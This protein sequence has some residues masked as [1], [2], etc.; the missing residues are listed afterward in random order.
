MITSVT[1]RFIL[2]VLSTSSTVSALM[3]LFPVTVSLHSANL[4]LRHC[5]WLSGISDSAHGHLYLSVKPLSP[6]SETLKR[7]H[8]FSG[9]LKRAHLFLWW[10]CFS[11][12]L[13][14]CVIPGV[15]LYSSAQHLPLIPRMHLYALLSSLL[16]RCLVWTSKPA[17]FKAPVQSDSS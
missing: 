7:A 16:T 8:M 14:I 13:D 3:A 17:A 10:H 15:L 12:T 2:A 4:F 1:T 5:H 9:T 6:V 11:W